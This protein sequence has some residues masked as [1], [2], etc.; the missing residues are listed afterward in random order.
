MAYISDASLLVGATY[1]NSHPTS[2]IEAQKT[3]TTT[4]FLPTLTLTIIIKLLSTFNNP[5][6]RSWTFKD[7]MKVF[8]ITSTS[9][10]LAVLGT[11]PAVNADCFGGKNTRPYSA[12]AV[13]EAILV[14]AAKM[15]YRGS[16]ADK[17][18]V[19]SN[20]IM[21]ADGG[22]CLNFGLKNFSG[23]WKGVSATDAADALL[24]EWVGCE[25]GGKSKYE[26]GLEFV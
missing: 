12:I 9:A 24:R 25:H 23:T 11:L 18:E 20:T 1:I 6:H 13:V 4:S 3:L 19:W 8:A 2:I 7:A 26:S 17:E 22:K 14:A 5:P 21:E 15:E 10:L 16:L